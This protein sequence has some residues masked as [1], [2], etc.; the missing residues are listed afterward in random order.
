MYPQ[1]QQFEEDNFMG[2]PPYGQE[3]YQQQTGMFPPQQSFPGV[4]QPQGPYPQT[5]GFGIGEPSYN[6]DAR[7]DRVEREIIEINRRLNTLSRHIRRIENVLNIRQ[8]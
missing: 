1:Q 6:V 3:M 8:D 4:G 5:P 2:R 7:L